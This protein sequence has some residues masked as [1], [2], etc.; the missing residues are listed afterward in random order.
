MLTPSF[1]RPFRRWL[2][3]VAIAVSVAGSGCQGKGGIKKVT[4]SGT[5][6]YKGQRLQSGILQFM[7]P[8]GAYSAASIQQDGTYIITDVVPGEVKVGV[9]EA[10]QASGS[11]SSSGGKASGPKAPPVTLPDKY[12]NAETSELKY[13][14]TADTSELNIDIP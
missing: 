4:V 12:R 5:V 11:S 6:S 14:I 7:G 1:R 9:M 10:P 2:G 3:L 13:T 8:G